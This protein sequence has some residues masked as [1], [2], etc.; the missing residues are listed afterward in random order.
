MYFPRLPKGTI[1]DPWRLFGWRVF[2]REYTG[3]ITVH[4]ERRKGG[5]YKVILFKAEYE[6]ADGSSQPREKEIKKRWV[7]QAKEV[8]TKETR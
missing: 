7:D 6:P 2:I 8:A 4:F 3:G 5:G 1:L